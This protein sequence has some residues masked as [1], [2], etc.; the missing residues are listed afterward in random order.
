MEI[1]K[2][3]SHWYLTKIPWNQLIHWSYNV[4]WFDEIFICEAKFSV[5]SHCAHCGKLG[6]VLPFRLCE[7][8]SLKVLSLVMWHFNSFST[9]ILFSFSEFS[10]P[11]PELKITKNQNSE[12]LKLSKLLFLILQ[13][14]PN[15]FHVNFEPSPIPVWVIWLAVTLLGG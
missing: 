10:N 13:Y 8:N 9:W 7:I 5:F 15:W 4:T 3:W 14:C 6:I 11:F 2:L 12:S 1:T